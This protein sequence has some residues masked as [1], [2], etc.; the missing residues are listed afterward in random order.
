MTTIPVGT[1]CLLV[2]PHELAGRTCVVESAPRFYHYLIDLR[3]GHPIA[4]SVAY[5][6]TPLSVPAEFESFPRSG[7]VA[8]RPELV[9]LTP[10]P[11]EQGTDRRA[12][13]PL[14]VPA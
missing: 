7:W 11:V 13:C 10:P 1:L 3:D 5:D 4:P 14:E 9:P 2:A 12:D 8:R 6:V